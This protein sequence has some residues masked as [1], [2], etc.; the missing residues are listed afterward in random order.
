VEFTGG[1]PL[2]LR[3]ATVSNVYDE[4]VAAN[5]TPSDALSAATLEVKWED[6]KKK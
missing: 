4:A 2:L 1:V 5:V 6:L 3:F